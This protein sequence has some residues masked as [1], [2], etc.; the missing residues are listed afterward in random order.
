MSIGPLPIVSFDTTRVLAMPAAAS[1]PRV[2]VG[3]C[4]L[5]VVRAGTGRDL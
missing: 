2:R 3:A 5:Q 1:F 4:Y